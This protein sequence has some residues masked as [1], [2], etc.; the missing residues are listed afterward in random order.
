MSEASIPVGLSEGPAVRMGVDL[1][2]GNRVGPAQRAQKGKGLCGHLEAGEK[3][4]SWGSL[5][6]CVYVNSRSW[7][8]TYTTT[9]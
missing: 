2:S 7:E 9:N 8:K 4:V 6:L 3:P 5:V 1:F